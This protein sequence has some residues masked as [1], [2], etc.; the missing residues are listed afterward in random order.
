MREILIVGNWKMNP[1]SEKVAQ[2]TFVEITKKIKSTKAISIA[3]CPPVLYL[4]L[5]KKNKSV[6][7]GSQNVFYEKEGAYTG[8]ISVQMLK[9]LGVKYVLVGHSERRMLG[10]NNEDI[11]K[12]ISTILKAGLLPIVC[13]GEKERDVEHKY[14]QFVEQEIKSACSLVSKNLISKMIFAYEPIWAIG[15]D[16]VRQASSE[17][18]REM[19]IFIHKII[20]DISTPNIS[21]SVKILYGGSVNEKNAEKFIKNGGMDGLLVGRASLNANQFSKLVESTGKIKNK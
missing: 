17:E 7:L 21:K 4:P 13:V 18:A 1:I 8:E 20:S 16:A 6:S 5:F 2:K 3:I 11:S 14:L 12:K 19:G 15:K 9:D 10:E